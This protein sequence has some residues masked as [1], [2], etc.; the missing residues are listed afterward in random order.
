[1][2]PARLA[3]TALLLQLFI[4]NAYSQEAQVIDQVVAVVGGEHILLS[5]I[6]QEF[7]RQKIFIIP[8]T[9]LIVLS[10]CN[11]LES[12]KGGYNRC[13]TGRLNC[14]LRTS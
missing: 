4:V 2:K 5:D 1:M 3:I 13:R 7:L 6:E 10:D 14:S 9:N 11:E 12:K 8:V